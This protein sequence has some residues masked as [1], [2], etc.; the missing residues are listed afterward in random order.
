MPPP[1]LSRNTPVTQIIDPMKINLF[2]S[3]W[4]YFD[5]LA[6][7]RVLQNFANIQFLSFPFYYSFIN[8]YK[9]LL[10]DLRL[11]N[12]LS[13]IVEGNVVDILCVNL[14]HQSFVF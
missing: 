12:P 7:Y 3:F 5:H 2:K 6:S 14:D 10:H 8:I 13:S 4:Y 1:N 11:Y 9:P